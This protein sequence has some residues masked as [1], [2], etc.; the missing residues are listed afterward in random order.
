MRVATAAAAAGPII[1]A[2]TRSGRSKAKTAVSD[3]PNCVLA[4]PLLQKRGTI[5]AAWIEE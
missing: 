5:I 1:T 3:R 2:D 4:L